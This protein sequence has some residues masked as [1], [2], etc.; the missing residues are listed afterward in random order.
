MIKEQRQHLVEFTERTLVLLDVL[1]EGN[2]RLTIGSLSRRL[3]SSLTETR[4]LLV[5]L[6]SRGM[7]EWDD[8]AK[9]YRLGSAAER[10]AWR[11][12]GITGKGKCQLPVNAAAD[13][14]AA[15][16][17]PAKRPGRPPRQLAV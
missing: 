5:S 1:A 13:P 6:E 8:T 15:A 4:L 9:A 7:V 17:Q 10:L 16:Q 14:P 12:L 11:L 2:S 3:G